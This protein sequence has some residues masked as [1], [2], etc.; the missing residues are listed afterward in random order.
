MR[1]LTHLLVIGLVLLSF[2]CSESAYPL[3]S[4]ESEGS[5]LEEGIEIR[6]A[7]FVRGLENPV[8]I[9]HAGDARLFVTE[10]RGRIRIIE[11]GNLRPEPFLDIRAKVLCCGE[12]GLLSVAFPPDYGSTGWFFVNYTDL[13][14]TTVIERYTVSS[15]PNR[16]DPSTGQMVLRIPQPFSNH[17]GGQLQFGPD[18]Y[19]Y[20]GMGDGGS[21][22]DPH[23]H[24]QNRGTLLGALLRIDV[25]SLPYTFP[26]DNPF[27]NDSSARPEI[28]A[29]GLRNPWRFTFDRE[30][31][32]LFIADVGQNLW[33][34]ISFQ[35]AGSSG[36]ENYGWNVMEGAHCYQPSAGC[37]PSSLV[38][39]ILEYGRGDGCSVT[40]GYRY[41]G[42]RW[43]Q[44]RG[45]YF[46][47]DY[48]SSRIWGA[49][50]NGAGPWQSRLLLEGKSVSPGM[51]VTT[52]GEDVRG[53][54]FVADWSEGTIYSIGQP[55]SR[56]RP[57]RR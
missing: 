24:A 15:D 53:E 29:Y 10:Q 9:T 41:R 2:K 35:P 45:V 47:S 44:L 11:R 39:P 32:D 18:G 42:N 13:T 54:L 7:S 17:N 27:V 48:C 55:T 38:L 5:A 23:R 36:G 37:N 26:P 14:G 31:G 52:F 46:Y 6:L 57:A 16:S 49:W 25:S 30:T 40:G 33:E 28:W 21:G 3:S 20:I 8:A 22:G 4:Q 12:R 50:P 1:K 51:R 56:R 19:L 43:P 34:E